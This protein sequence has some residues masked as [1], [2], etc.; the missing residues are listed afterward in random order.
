MRWVIIVVLQAASR[1]VTICPTCRCPAWAAVTGSS[2]IMSPVRITGDIDPE[3][4]V[5]TGWPKT[6]NWPLGDRWLATASRIISAAK[7]ETITVAIV[8][9]ARRAIQQA[10]GWRRAL[11]CAG[12]AADPEIAVVLI[13]LAPR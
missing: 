7:T 3:S 1:K 9:N 11:R 5:I 13:S 6:V 2:T 12:Q 8:E 4:I 10:G